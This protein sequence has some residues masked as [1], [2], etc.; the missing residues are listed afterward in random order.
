VKTVVTR[1]LKSQGTEVY[2]AG[3]NK[4]VPWLDKCLNLGQTMLKNKVISIE[5]IWYLFCSKWQYIH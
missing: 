3:I 4:L 5:N 2:E 1:W